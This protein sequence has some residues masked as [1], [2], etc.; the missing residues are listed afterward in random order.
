M[1]H[2]PVIRRAAAAAARAISPALS[3]TRF[4]LTVMVPVSLAVMLLDRSGLLAS[5]ATLLDPVMRFLGL[6][7]KASLVFLSGA[8]LSN[9]SAIAVIG[10]LSLTGREVAILAVMCLI[11]HNLIVE[12]AV[13]RKTGSSAL[14]MALLRIGT[15][16]AAAWILNRVMPIDIGS[17]V[18]STGPTGAE[19]ALTLALMP[20]ILGSWAID[21]GLLV[22]KI[23]VIVTLLLV[24]QKIM[25]EFGTM[26]LLGRIT[27]PFMF[28]FGLPAS[29]GFLWIISNVTGLAYGAAIM[30][31]RAES[32]KLSQ[33]DGDLFNHHAG[34]SHSLVE[35]T[36]LY[37]AIGVP[38]FWLFVPRV[39]LAIAVVWIERLRRVLF[40]RSFRVGTI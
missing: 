8:L 6:S 2:T 27:A 11:A 23:A 34:I 33:S 39:M 5:A 3:T 35:D 36:I 24:V 15:A 10:T 1:D 32:G 40:R 26:E 28:L 22:L 16:V 20:S 13:M 19:K 17:A 7:G 18:S 4:L 38:F 25:D 12:C 21:S 30:I 9:Y 31:D 29:A 14:K 37:M